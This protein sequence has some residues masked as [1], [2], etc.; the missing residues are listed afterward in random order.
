M[1]VHVFLITQLGIAL[2][3]TIPGFGGQA[4]RFC[5]RFQD[6]LI[7]GDGSFQVTFG[8]LQLHALLQ[9]LS[10]RLRLGR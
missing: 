8:T 10:C 3:E 2:G 4:L 7:L 9:S 5:G 6:G 1:H